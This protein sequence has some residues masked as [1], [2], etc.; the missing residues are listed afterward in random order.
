[1][2]YFADITPSEMKTINSSMI[3][4]PQSINVFEKLLILP[5]KNTSIILPRIIANIIFT[6][7]LIMVDNNLNEN[8]PL[9]F[10]TYFILFFNFIYNLA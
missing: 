6:I 8:N 1:M 3:N 4:I 2:E 10:Y 9:Y 7:D 5:D